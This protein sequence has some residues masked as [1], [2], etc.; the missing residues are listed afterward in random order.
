MNPIKIFVAT[1]LAGVIFGES[2]MAEQ[3]LQT[4]P[5]G[6][7]HIEVSVEVPILADLSSPSASGGRITKSVADKIDFSDSVEISVLPFQSTQI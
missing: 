6:Q 4:A 7:Q 1:I 5:V 2:T 3:H